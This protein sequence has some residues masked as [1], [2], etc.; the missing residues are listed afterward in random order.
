MPRAVVPRRRDGRRGAALGLAVALVHVAPQQ[1]AEEGVLDRWICGRVRTEKRVV[2][3][4]VV[5]RKFLN[6]REKSR[7]SEKWREKRKWK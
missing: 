4:C 3:Q 7:K 1:H 6:R 2:A 5:R